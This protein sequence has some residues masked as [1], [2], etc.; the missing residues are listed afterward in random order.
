MRK[1]FAVVAIALAL[2]GCAGTQVGD[3][4]SAA[5]S[6]ITNPVDTTQLYRAENV[7]TATL[8]LAADYRAYCY[9]RPYKVLLADPVGK[10]LCQ[11]R[12]D[13]IRK[14]QAAQL[15]VQAVAERARLFMQN[16]PTVNASTAISEVWN[17]VLAFQA[18]VP[19][20]PG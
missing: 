9:A 14:I 12:R 15:K 7:Y 3:F 13:V 11:S 4:I 10:S 19:K 17:A 16:N 20:I 8:Q 18:A 2:S 1:L 5:T 6:S